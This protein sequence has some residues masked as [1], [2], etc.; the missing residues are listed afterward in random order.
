LRICTVIVA[1]GRHGYARECGCANANE[2][3]PDVHDL[4]PHAS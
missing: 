4:S 3:G 2:T 1:A